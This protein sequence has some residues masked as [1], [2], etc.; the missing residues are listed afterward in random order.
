M[1]LTDPSADI[2]AQ[3]TDEG[4]T[5]IA[6]AT[7]GDVVFKVEGFAVGRGGYDP[8]N[9]V[10]TLPLDPAA[11]ELSD[12]VYPDAT[13]LSFASFISTEEPKASVRVYNCRVAASPLSGNADYGLGELGLYGTIVHSSDPTEIGQVF[14]Y[15]VSHF[16]IMCKT[17][18]DTFLRRVVVSY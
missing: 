7:L 14:L 6:R 10:D 5:L 3:V 18:R 16:P 13:P 17:R 15:A 8:S 2:I 1:S 9:V 12:K 11:V 4:R